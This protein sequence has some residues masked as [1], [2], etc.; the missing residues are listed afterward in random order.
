MSGRVGWVDATHGISG[1][2]LL[3]ACL[4]AGVELAVIQAAIDRLGLPEPIA[5]TREPVRR[6]ALAATKAVVSKG[7]SDRRR[8]L[9]DVLALL[10]RSDPDVGASAA[11]VF[12]TLAEA[13]A[14]VHQVEVE[15][16]HFHEVGALDS[17]ADVV[18]VVAGL[19][20]LGMNR[21]VCSPIA[22][23]GGRAQT[24]HGPIP[25]PGPAVVELLRASSA[26]ALGGPVEIELAT[27]TGVALMVTLADEF[28]PLPSMRPELVG[29][30]AGDR[31][32]EG[33]PNLTRLVVGEAFGT[34]TEADGLEPALAPAVVLEANVDD[35][36]PRLWP[37]VLAELLAAGASDAWLTPILMKKGRP[38][39]TLS[40]LA[41]PEYTERLE[42]VVFAQTSTIGLRRH[43]VDK[44]ALAREFVVVEVHD[45]QIRVK[46][47][48]LNGRIVNAV[49]E[50]D[51]VARVAAER[52]VPATLVLDEARVAAQALLQQ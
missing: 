51:D 6:G 4:D 52:G 21:L 26:P 46:V 3:G 49:P 22:L 16:V 7:T 50:Y 44:R 10:D 42:Q 1:D 48:R 27:P 38:A 37:Q 28:G 32:P 12:R 45:Q 41:S 29:M 11:A 33:H 8:T 9:V 39:H 13:E 17:I 30:G 40:V 34:T 14:R 47:A 43:P 25:V 36:D 35:L 18:G 24:E 20:A 5:V 15:K 2:M 31:D 19:R 23:G